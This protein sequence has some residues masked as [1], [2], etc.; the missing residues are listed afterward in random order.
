MTVTSPPPTSRVTALLTSPPSQSQSFFPCR[1]PKKDLLYCARKTGIRQQEKRE[2]GFELG[3]TPIANKYEPGQRTH[4][5]EVLNQPFNE[6]LRCLGIM[7]QIIT[8][9]GDTVTPQI[10]TIPMTT[11]SENNVREDCHLP[12]G[13]VSALGF[14]LEPAKKIFCKINVDEGRV[15]WQVG[16]Q[17]FF[18]SVHAANQQ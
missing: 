13:P 7:P 8:E 14:I 6:N 10:P 3:R 15:H 16:F 12:V 4:V 17:V 11:P 1:D 5:F 18:L 2:F 9:K